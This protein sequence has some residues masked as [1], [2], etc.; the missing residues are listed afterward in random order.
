MLP[1]IGFNQQAPLL[2]GIDLPNI[3]RVSDPKS[4]ND[5]CH[6]Y[7]SVRMKFLEIKFI[8]K[9]FS[10]IIKFLRLKILRIIIG[11]FWIDFV[12]Q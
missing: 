7:Y 2:Y 10:Q 1:S 3:I 9:F 5:R 8:L 4:N 6:I 12:Q 11:H